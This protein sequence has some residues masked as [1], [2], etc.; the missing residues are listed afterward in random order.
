L[1][2]LLKFFRKKKFI[3]SYKITDIKLASEVNAGWF[4]Q[5][6]NFARGLQLGH[7]SV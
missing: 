5:A 2:D 7:S 4:G 6:S 1:K 3:T